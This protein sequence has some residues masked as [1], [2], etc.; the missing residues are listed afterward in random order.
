MCG[1]E[2]VALGPLCFS[3]N[4]ELV[5]GFTAFYIAGYFH[6]KLLDSIIAENTDQCNAIAADL[7]HCDR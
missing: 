2:W 6:R 4:L 3:G 7:L 1:V 5:V